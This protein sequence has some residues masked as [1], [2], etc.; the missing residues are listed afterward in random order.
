MDIKSLLKK[1]NFKF[2]MLKVKTKIENKTLHI[3]RQNIRSSI[4]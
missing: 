1:E 3:D 2:S 4:V